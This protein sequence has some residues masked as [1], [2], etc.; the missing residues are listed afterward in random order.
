MGGNNGGYEIVPGLN[1]SLFFLVNYAGSKC[2]N[3]V[4]F[5]L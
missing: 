1:G 3:K 5:V 4:T 2:N